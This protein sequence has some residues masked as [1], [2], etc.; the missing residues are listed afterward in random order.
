MKC[1]STTKRSTLS[2]QCL[3]VV[4]TLATLIGSTCAFAESCAPESQITA[5]ESGGEVVY[6]AG[7]FK[8]NNE[9]SGNDENRSYLSPTLKFER[10]TLSQRK[11]GTH[12]EDPK[13][14]AGSIV[15]FVKCDYVGAGG[16]KAGSPPDRVR[17]SKRYTT[18]P[19]PDKGNWLTETINRTV[20][21]NSAGT[22]NTYCTSTDPT[23]CTF[24]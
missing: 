15:S 4:I 6:T 22:E 8:G 20:V 17:L 1:L 10:A 16:S 13:D 7:E 12:G 11:I 24:K 5:S 14:T 21:T 19:K 18:L 3:K 2:S 23:A 9:D